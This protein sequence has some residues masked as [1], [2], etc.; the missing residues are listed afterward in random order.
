MTVRSCQVLFAEMS[1]SGLFICI[2][3]NQYKYNCFSF[4]FMPVLSCFIVVASFGQLYAVHVPGS[5]AHCRVC[6]YEDT[7]NETIEYWHK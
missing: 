5:T 6:P 3:A 2:I 7:E 1:W 4:S